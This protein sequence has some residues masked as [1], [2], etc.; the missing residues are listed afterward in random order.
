MY[1]IRSYYVEYYGVKLDTNALSEYSEILK[2]EIN[3]IEKDIYTHSGV[4]FNIASPKQLGEVLFEKLKIT[5]K[6][7]LT[8]TKQYATGEDVLTNLKEKHPIVNLILEYRTLSKLLS[9][10]VDALPKLVHEKTGKIH[11]SSYNFV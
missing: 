11:T 10:Y 7:K 6:P 2:N 3:I 4:E 1:A 9:T 8:K 5:D